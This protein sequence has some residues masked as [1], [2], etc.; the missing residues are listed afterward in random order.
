[1]KGSRFGRAAVAAAVAAVMAAAAIVVC[2]PALATQNAPKK[3]DAAV[4]VAVAAEPADPAGLQTVYVAL[5]ID[6]GWHIYANPVG[7]ENFSS[8]QTTVTPQPPLTSQSIQVTYPPGRK[9]EDPVVGTYTIY[10]GRVVLKALVQRNPGDAT[11]VQLQVKFQACC[12]VP[13][14]E[15]CLPPAVVTVTVP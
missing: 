15:K 1:M 10:E 7:N 3:S 4:K 13:Q 8:V 2:S 5:T 9:M 6:Q 12:H 14:Q 11:P